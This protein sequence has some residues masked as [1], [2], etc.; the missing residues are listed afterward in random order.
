MFLSNR[1]RNSL[2]TS[3][4][5]VPYIYQIWIITQWM[6]QDSKAIGETAYCQIMAAPEFG[7]P[8]AGQEASKEEAERLTN[9][10]EA[11]SF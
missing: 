2:G 9:P 10:A 6:R 7:K 8:L 4:E 3:Y 5:N 11:L 1:I